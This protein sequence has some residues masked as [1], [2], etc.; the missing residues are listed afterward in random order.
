ML[1]L[2]ITDV[3]ETANSK[4]IITKVVA[5]FENKI[6]LSYQNNTFSISACDFVDVQ[7]FFAGKSQDDVALILADKARRKHIL[8]GAS[9]PFCCQMVERITLPESK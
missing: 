4:G 3:I 7:P 5:E 2:K 9:A 6:L 8:S 1:N